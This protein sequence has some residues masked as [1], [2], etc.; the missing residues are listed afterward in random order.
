[1]EQINIPK[2]LTYTKNGS[3]FLKLKNTGDFMNFNKFIETQLKN[4]IKKNNLSKK[5]TLLHTGNKILKSK[6]RNQ[7]WM[8]EITNSCWH[9][10][11][12]L[13][14]H[15]KTF[16]YLNA[17]DINLSELPKK[18]IFYNLLEF[19][20]DFSKHIKKR[21][22][23]FN[24]YYQNKNVKNTKII[25]R[26]YYTGRKY[27]CPLDIKKYLEEVDAIIA[28]KQ[29]INKYLKNITY[30][31][32]HN[33]YSKIKNTVVGKDIAKIFLEHC[34]ISRKLNFGGFVNFNQHAES[35]SKNIG[36]LQL[37]SEIPKSKKQF[38]EFYRLFAKEIYYKIAKQPY[39]IMP[40]IPYLHYYKGIYRPNHGTLNIMRQ[41]LFTMKVMQIFKNNNSNLF[42]RVF[43][44]KPRLHIF[45]FISLLFQIMRVGE[46]ISGITESKLI[47]IDLTIVKELFPSLEYQS[48]YKNTLIGTHIYSAI[49]CKS[50]LQQYN[51]DKKEVDLLSAITFIYFK[52][53]EYG[54]NKTMRLKNYKFENVN[55]DTIFVILTF[56]F[57]SGHY[58]DHCRG[59]WSDIMEKPF[60][61]V[62]L[63]TIKATKTDKEELIEFVQKI[64]IK[65]QVNGQV[66]KG[67]HCVSTK[68]CCQ[69][70]L[71]NGRYTNKKFTMYSKNFDKLYNLLNYP[72]EIQSL[73]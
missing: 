5:H 30:V 1:M 15:T 44:T 43:N 8:E 14:N 18:L 11:Q 24:T 66:T 55:N 42:D 50:I 60:F 38:I 23:L 17:K 41:S 57:A 28:S 48:L 72:R 56:L 40:H 62:L 12:L 25:G 47:P 3:T 2:Y 71:K 21:P 53:D 39:K 7:L 59:P 63:N 45:I 35:F 10:I 70:L 36:Q 64:L 58:L 19:E 29:M 51:L 61:K 31:Y 54:N 37:P 69:K 67:K 16:S 32:L 46:G 20:N 26:T 13:Y 65:T 6:Q 68:K 49:F 27:S 22:G 9:T 73:I 4:I 33:N 34:L 52:I